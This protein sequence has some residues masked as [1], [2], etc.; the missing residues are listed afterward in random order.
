MPVDSPSS[1]RGRREDRAPAGAHGPRAAKS[2]RQ[3]HRLNRETPGLPC[4]MVWRLIRDLPGDRLDCPRRLADHLPLGLTSAPGGQDHTVSPSHRFVR[5]HDK[6][7]LQTHTPT[8]SH[9]SVRD[10]RETPL[11]GKAETGKNVNLIC[12]TTQAEPH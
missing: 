3:N 8:A 4:A 10:D 9:P 11:C 2:T 6:I 5:P 12:P 1:D 7:N